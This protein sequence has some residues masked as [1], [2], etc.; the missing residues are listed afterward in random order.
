MFVM[1]KPGWSSQAF[2]RSVF[3]ADGKRLKTMVFQP[4]EVYE[5][6]DEAEL[7]AIQKDLD[8]ALVEVQ[9]DGKG[10]PRT[11]DGVAVPTR[12]EDIESIRPVPEEPP[13]ALDVEEEHGGKRGRKKPKDED[14]AGE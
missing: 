7:A 6:A 1:L 8:L 11:K 4:G 2:H 5:I 12:I 3:D 9:P 13:K 10:R 14:Q